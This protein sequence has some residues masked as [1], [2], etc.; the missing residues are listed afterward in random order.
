M[1]HLSLFWLLIGALVGLLA[2]A[3][4]MPCSQRL[5]GGKL[6][7]I[8]AISTLAGGWLGTRTLGF[9]FATGI[10]LWIALLMLVMIPLATCGGK[11]KR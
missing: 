2:S 6:I 10:A 1:L 5:R 9:F 8:G 7:A 3:L 4:R 11:Q